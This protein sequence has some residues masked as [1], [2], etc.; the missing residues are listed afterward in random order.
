MPM[1][2][3]I[4]PE[5]GLFIIAGPCVIESADLCLS[6]ARHVK[7]VC[8]ALGLPYIFKAS[9]DKA[10]RSAANS[11]RGPGLEDG[12]VVLGRI[13]QELGVPV[14]SDIHEAHQAAAAAKVVDVLQVPAFL[15][16]QTDL[17]VAC[18]RTGRTVNIKKGQFMSPQEM[19]LALEKVR[20]TG[21]DNVM[22]TERGTFFGYSRLVNDFTAL[23]IMK[24]FGK[25]VVFDVTHS[26]QQ[27]AGQGNQSG[28]DPQ[29]AP[30]LARAAV[31]AGVDGLFLECHPDPKSA[32][33]DPATMLALEQ[34]QPLLSQCRQL[35]DLRRRW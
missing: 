30:L 4:G 24:Q 34:V 31:A 32:K 6:I 35:A 17:L 27:P 11:F 9:F 33:S 13:K 3:L 25:P 16:R 14:L 20:S 12:L 15:A 1:R 18:G 8:D 19:G 23:A 29:F 22:L 10:N 7:A 28:G 2:D 21:N 26:T 5:G